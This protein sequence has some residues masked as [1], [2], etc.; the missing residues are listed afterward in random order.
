[1]SGK[2]IAEADMV[3][4]NFLMDAFTKVILSMENHKDWGSI[5]GRMASSM[6]DNG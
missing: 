4:K 3:L 5:N 1:M 2:E 6:K